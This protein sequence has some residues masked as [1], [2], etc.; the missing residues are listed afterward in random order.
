MYERHNHLEKKIKLWDDKKDEIVSALNCVAPLR[1]YFSRPHK[2][3]WLMLYSRELNFAGRRLKALGQDD[4]SIRIILNTMAANASQNAAS[5]QR[6]SPQQLVRTVVPSTALPICDTR[7]AL[8]SAADLQHLTQDSTA[9]RSMKDSDSIELI[10]SSEP[11]ARHT[12]VEHITKRRRLGSRDEIEQQIN[13]PFGDGPLHK[14]QSR[15]LMPPPVVPMKQPSVYSARISGSPIQY[16]LGYDNRSYPTHTRGTTPQNLKPQLVPPRGSVNFPMQGQ[17]FSASGLDRNLVF[18]DRAAPS[19][20]FGVRPIS[21]LQR[22]LP[23]DHEGDACERRL[24][25]GSLP[26]AFKR[27]QQVQP[28]FGRKPYPVSSQT[29]PLGVGSHTLKLS[30]HGH[31]PWS[32]SYSYSYNGDTYTAPRMVTETK[33][34]SD[35]PTIPEISP[36]RH[37][38]NAFSRSQARLS[39]PPRNRGMGLSSHARSSGQPSQFATFSRVSRQQDVSITPARQDPLASPYFRPQHISVVNDNSRAAIP[40]AYGAR[41]TGR[42]IHLQANRT[43]TPIPAPAPNGLYSAQIRDNDRYISANRRRA[44][45]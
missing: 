41:Q 13:Y 42:I 5:D 38:A 29:S 26:A 23:P 7:L 31:T 43:A 45:R 14:G 9:F 24:I 4:S 3:Q 2:Y 18:S 32:A 21:E 19:P 22:I 35:R 1:R 10:M 30:P 40:L 33:Y 8:G 15:D 25:N 44:D 37:G 12:K 27:P 11:Q 17:N 6:V 34:N 39:L 28:P 36:S 16:A 20:D